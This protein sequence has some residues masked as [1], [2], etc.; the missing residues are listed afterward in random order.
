M[1]VGGSETHGGSTGRWDYLPEALIISD[2]YYGL[3]AV[4]PWK[5]GPEF[6]QWVIGVL[7][8]LISTSV[9]AVAKIA[10]DVKMGER[11]KFWTK[12]LWLDFPALLMMT[13]AAISVTEYLDLSTAVGVGL[14]T[15][16]GWLGPRTLDL[17]IGYKVRSWL[18]RK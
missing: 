15:F 3:E 7:A 16:L 14:G 9:G 11:H 6:W 4:V 5:N 10:D 12:Q 17:F 2:T 8:M 18:D 1:T 13:I